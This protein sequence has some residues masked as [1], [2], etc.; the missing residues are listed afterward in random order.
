M[1]RL[2]Y[3]AALVVGGLMLALMTATRFL[4]IDDA[5]GDVARGADLYYGAAPHYLQCYACHVSSAAAPRVEGILDRVIHTRLADPQN[6]HK[7]AAY[8]LAESIIAPRQYL[9]PQYHDHMPRYGL[10]PGGKRRILS[11]QDIRDLIA[12]MMT[13]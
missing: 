8:Y 4:N 13:L 10:F 9:V 6:N 12:F 11:L 2:I 3:R 7:T 1:T 5:Q